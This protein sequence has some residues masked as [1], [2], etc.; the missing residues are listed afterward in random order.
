MWAIIL[1][2]G[3]IMID[4]CGYHSSYD[5]AIIIAIRVI[6]I[7]IWDIILAIGAII[8]ALMVAN[9]IAFW[10]YCNRYMGLL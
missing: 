3:A 6:L 5:G 7:A 10:G 1:A 9:L 2:I 8:V 4:F